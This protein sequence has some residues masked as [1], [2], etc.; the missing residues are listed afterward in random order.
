MHEINIGDTVRT[1]TKLARPILL[2]TVKD[3]YRDRDK[4]IRYVVEL[5]AFPRD[6][7]D[8]DAGQ[9]HGVVEPVEVV[10]KRGNLGGHLEKYKKTWI[11][12]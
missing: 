12:D 10:P 4:T 9:I 1:R 2:G 5:W 3:I 6:P 7:V 11:R 8:I